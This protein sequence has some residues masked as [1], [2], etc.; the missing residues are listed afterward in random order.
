METMASTRHALLQMSSGCGQVA[1]KWLWLA[2]WHDEINLVTEG[3]T[4]IS[5]LND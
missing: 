5:K 3:S 2:P 1:C 4:R